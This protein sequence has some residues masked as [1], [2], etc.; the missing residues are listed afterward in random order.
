MT[1][2][3]PT[4]GASI[5]ISGFQPDTVSLIKSTIAKGCTDIELRLFLAQCQRTG[6]DPF[7]RQIYALKQYDRKEGREVMRVQLSIDGL[8]LIAQR[9]GQYAGQVGPEW[10]GEDGKWVDVWLSA[11]PP[12][13]ARVGVIRKGFERPLYAVARF[14]SYA[15]TTKEGTLT[16]MWKKMPDIMIA[17]CA[18]ALALR[19]AFP[20]EL[21]GLYTA[22][23]MEQAAP[24]AVPVVERD[25]APLVPDFVDAATGDA[26]DTEILEPNADGSYT[27]PKTGKVAVP[28]Q[29][30][31]K[32]P[33]LRYTPDRL[34]ERV[35]DKIGKWTGSPATE[36][37][38][39][40]L[41]A[42]IERMFAGEDD[43]TNKR[44][45]VTTF[46]VGKDSTK[47]M[48]DAEVAVLTA[49]V[50]S[51]PDE[52]GEWWPNEASSREARAIVRRALIDAGQTQLFGEAS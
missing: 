6:L 14:D 47:S 7:S 5:A 44:R 3:V 15:G 26:I 36:Q 22:D 35:T 29:V 1:D 8:R 2:L 52:S 20:Q 34:K 23:E 43:A 38:R 4:S 51:K 9:S 33:A 45:S 25:H 13:A 17:K 39:H 31:V 16:P 28:L 24:V 10:C 27:N 46:L 11:K 50:D 40:M 48:T 19:K 42:N 18:E 41:A 21:S 37:Q 32:A 30:E 12:S 49:W